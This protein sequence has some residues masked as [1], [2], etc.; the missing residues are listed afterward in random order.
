MHGAGGGP[1]SHSTVWSGMQNGQHS[2]ARPEQIYRP[3]GGLSVKEPAGWDVCATR[4]SGGKVLP[5]IAVSLLG[6]SPSP[7]QP[8]EMG[9]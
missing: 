4:L 8:A 6:L 2:G 3:L 1:A 7:Q 9:P 5:A